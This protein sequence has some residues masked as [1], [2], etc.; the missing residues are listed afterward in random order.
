MHVAHD[1]LNNETLIIIYTMFWTV[2]RFLLMNARPW[3]GCIARTVSERS[4][5]RLSLE[6]QEFVVR[7]GAR[8]NGG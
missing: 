6:R 1:P 3:R 7:N 8:R 2:P 5:Y 4:E